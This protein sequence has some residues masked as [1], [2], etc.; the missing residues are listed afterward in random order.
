[1]ALRAI[2]KGLIKEHRDI[3]Y[4][5]LDQE[6]FGYHFKNP[7]G[8]AAGFDKNGVAVSHWHAGGFGFVEIGTVTYHPQ[9][10]NPKPRMFRYPQDKAIINRLGFNNIGAHGVANNLSR[11]MTNMP[12]GINIGKSFVTPIE[13]AAEDYKN[14]LSALKD[15]GSYITINVSSPNTP[16]LRSLQEKDKLKEIIK[17]L[18]TVDIAVPMFVKVAPDLEFSALDEVVEVVLETNITG[19]IAT[20]T[21]IT[22]DGMVTQTAEA[23]GLSGR[24]LQA[25]SNKVLAHL[26]KQCGQRLVLIGVGGIFTGADLYQKIA[27]GANLCQMYTGWV[28]GGPNSVPEIL[29][30]CV[31]LMEQRGYKN[32]EELRGSALA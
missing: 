2:E 4:S 15:F 10:G 19:I 23:G 1:M 27:L 16:G 9:P 32:V 3:T 8:L 22:R 17:A 26:A 5:Q 24:P 28:Y 6:L 13:D 14:C 31:H 11:A 29:E 7:L 20:N 21:T 18:R 30:S 25:L 12:Y